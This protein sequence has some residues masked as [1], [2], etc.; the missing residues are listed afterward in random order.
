[1]EKMDLNG[2]MERWRGAKNGL[3]RIGKME[4]DWAGGVSDKD[5]KGQIKKYVYYLLQYKLYCR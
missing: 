2:A 3:W 4:N 1:M 5:E